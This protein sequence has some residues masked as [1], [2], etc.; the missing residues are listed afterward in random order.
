MKKIGLL[1]L[2][3][4]LLFSCA[5][6]QHP[7]DYISFAGTLKNTQDSIL[8][9]T[10]F[11]VKKKIKLN[12][13]GSFSDSLK[14]A[15][16]NF[17][18]F[19]LPKSGRTSVYLDNG[20]DLKLTGDANEFFTS[21]QYEGNSVGAQSNNF[22]VNQ[23][24]F[25]RTAGTQKDF[26]ILEKEAFQKRI[27]YYRNGLDSVI[28]LYP[29][30]HPDLIKRVTEQN[31]G[32]LGDMEKNYDRMHTAVVAQEKAFAKLR[33]GQ[34]APEFSN[35]EDYKGGTKSL[36]DFRGNFVYIDVWATWCRP[37]LAQIPYLKKL[38][39]EFEG[40]NISFVSISTD[41]SRRS[42]G[43]WK[44]ARDKWRNM[45]KEKEMSGIQLWA[46]EDKQQFSTNYMT[47]TIPRFILI[48]PEGKM[49]NH[50]EMRPSSP[51]ISEYLTS[52]GVK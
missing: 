25:G 5:E 17:Y 30:A 26:V 49:I 28:K 23:F 40:K 12:A 20:Y 9:I 52:L 11:G 29:D 51:N 18:T 45:V 33:K 42:Q 39:K 36:K 22:L 46:G 43:S 48:D 7:K 4:I 32:F 21:F 14:V 27:D 2:S 24:L 1:F 38:E 31:K 50:D 16:P 8:Y 10:G 6:K 15:A 44:K 3:L 37:C 47:N 13:D 41:G 34:P 19:S 35:Y